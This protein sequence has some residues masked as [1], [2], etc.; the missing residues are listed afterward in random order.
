AKSVQFIELP[1]VEY[2]P[3]PDW[4]AW[5]PGDRQLFSAIAHDRTVPRTT[6]KTRP[7]RPAVLAAADSADA[8]VRV[9]S[10][11]RLRGVR[12]ARHQPGATPSPSG[13]PQN[14][15]KKFGGITG[16]A[17]ICRNNQAFAGPRRGT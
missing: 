9:P 11:S 5:P 6:S 10:E 14:L 3:N 8:D 7:T 2:K 12:P 15:I 16:N 4:V 13:S 17:N 1:T